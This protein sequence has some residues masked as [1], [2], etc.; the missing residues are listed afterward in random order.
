MNNVYILAAQHISAQPPL[1]EDWMDSPLLHDAPYVRAIDPDYK[2][3]FP[4]NTVRRLGRILKRALLV[5]QQVMQA[6]GISSPDAVITA[7]GLGCI[8]NTGI[9]LDALTHEGEGLLMPACFMHSTHNTIGSLIAIHAH[10]HGYNSTYSHKGISF[11]SA[12]LDAFMQLQNGEIQTALVGAHDELTP[13][14]FK[15]L[16][17]VG[18]VGPMTNS[19]GSETALALMLSTAPGP[20]PL[21]RLQGVEIEYG[22][23]SEALRQTLGRFLR[24]TACR[25]EEIDAV[26]TGADCRDPEGQD[27]D[28]RAYADLCRVLFPAQKRLR[29]KHLFGRSF[30]APALGFYAAAM[31][32]HRQRIPAHLWAD[33][34]RTEQRGVKHILLYH[35][36]ENKNHSF[37]L[38]SSCGK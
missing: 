9:F 6:T 28:S 38:L 19:F 22:A 24:Q 2:P 18:Y 30:T 5:S 32:L 21:C 17:R 3:Y 14:Y 13:D 15:L 12:L 26:M 37:I 23:G 10:C 35:Q 8:E 34:P 1:C 31:C 7:T 20:Q 25:P 33:A 16:S 11:E 27:P 29:Y 4:P 36:C